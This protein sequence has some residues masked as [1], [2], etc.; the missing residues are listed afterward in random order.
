MPFYIWKGVNERLRI[1]NA[2]LAIEKSLPTLEPEKEIW[3]LSWLILDYYNTNKDKNFRQIKIV[4][5]EILNLN[6]E[7]NPGRQI[8]MSSNKWFR[9]YFI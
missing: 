3:Q 7:K 5:A 8:S 4:E 6:Q 1:K 2:N 9:N